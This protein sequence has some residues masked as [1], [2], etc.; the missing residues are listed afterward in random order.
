M[1]K[2]HN[3]LLAKLFSLLNKEVKKHQFQQ[4]SSSAPPFSRRAFISQSTK[5]TAALAIGISM[6]GIL[7]SC[8]SS[9]G[10]S[11]STKTKGNSEN[12]LD[13]AILGAGM[14]GLNCANHL[15]SSGLNF[16]IFE[17][18]KRYGGRI[19]THYND[20]MQLGIFPEFGG[21]FVDSDHE[22]ML[23]LAKEFNLELIDLIKEQ[24]ENHWE[25]DI[26]FFDNRKITEKEIIKEFKKIAPG[27]AKDI[28]SLGEDYNTEAA[29]KLDNTPLSDYINQLKCA[30]WLKDLFIA[31]WIAEYG[32]DCKEQS[33]LNMLD[34]VDTDTTKGFYVFGSSDERYR[35]KGGNS[36]VIEGLVDKIG[37]NNIVSHFEVTRVEEL[38]D[39][40]YKISF[41][42]EEPVIAISVVCTI[43][44][45]ILRK[46]ELKLKNMPA[47]KRKCID[48]LGYGN[49][50]KIILGYEGQ[51]WRSKENNAMGYLFTN[52]MTNG[53]DATVNKTE[54]NTNGAYVAYF[55]GAFSQKLCDQSS[56]SPMAPPD[57]EWRTALPEERVNGFVTE[58]DKIFKH[59][60]E[61]FLGKHVF[62]NWIEFPWVKASYSCYKVGQWTTISGWEMKPVGNF[63]FAGEH[64][65]EMFQG[66]MNGAAETGR[67]VAT[68]IQE[69]LK[70][71]AK[72]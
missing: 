49:N 54:N 51:P 59:S 33:T 36:K 2:A 50:T 60:K 26:F 38:E 21:D 25:K 43:P 14:A 67:R 66:F 32:L 19:L 65:S 23:S 7:N 39:G 10:D 46:L 41:K 18:S 4:S 34:M 71:K 44:F 27:I 72:I 17:G 48:E 24:E 13:V 29:K 45:T 5:A 35:I 55:G 40:S 69:T 62:V 12:I 30:K 61:K 28:S 68:L 57:H 9:E 47:E 8:K 3:N 11:Q 64:C 52:D 22:D 20:A 56:K 70:E 53:W 1:K 37:K 58:L 31:A 63:F 42:N 6:P 16:K 15:L